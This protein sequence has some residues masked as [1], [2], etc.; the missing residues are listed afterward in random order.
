[1]RHR[2][3]VVAV[4][5]SRLG[6]GLVF[7]Y[8]QTGPANI[9]EPVTVAQPDWALRLRMWN[10]I[11]PAHTPQCTI[12]LAESCHFHVC[13]RF[14]DLRHRC[15]GS[16]SH[17]AAHLKSGFAFRWFTSATS[18]MTGPR[19]A[20]IRMASDFIMFS[21]SS[22]MRCVVFSSRLQCRLTTCRHASATSKL[23]LCH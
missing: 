22:F 12:I 16:C 6:F 15:M 4:Q 5:Q 23:T 9:T 10:L 21:R 19:E 1:M 7:K 3:D 14:S 8:V 2:H 11:S 20:L 13:A 17:N 18:S